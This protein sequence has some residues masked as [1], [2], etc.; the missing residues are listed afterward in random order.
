MNIAI[1]IDDTLTESFSYFQPYVAEFFGVDLQ[2]LRSH[3][4]SYSNL[5]PQLKNRELEFCKTYYDKI[6]PATPFK[7]DAAWG[8]ARLKAMGHR[9]LILTGRTTAFYTAPYATTA[10][11]LKNGGIPY[12]K[13]ICTLEKGEACIREHID[14]LID[15]MPGNCDDAASRGI[16]TLLFTSPANAGTETSHT[17]VTSWKD[18]IAIL[19]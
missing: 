11:E 8:V 13:L 15:D 1:D 10:E 7:S 6:V 18:I 2:T 9:I 16:R 3:G 4:I 5:P 12:D 14:L 17:R 19:A